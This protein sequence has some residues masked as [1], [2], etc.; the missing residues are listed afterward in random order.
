MY[1]YVSATVLGRSPGAQWVE[2]DLQQMPL[3]VIFNS[4]FGVYLTLTIPAQTDPLYV[5]LELLRPELS[6][7]PDTLAVWLNAIGNRTLP[8]VEEIPSS[9]VAYATFSDAFKAAYKVDT[10]R[11][12]DNVPIYFPPT[13]T[14]TALMTRPR[15]DTDLR[16]IDQYCLV[17][18]NGYFHRTASDQGSTYIYDGLTTMR[19]TRDNHVGILSFKDVGALTKIRLTPEQIYKQAA[20]SDLKTRTYFHI[21]QDITGKAVF[22]VL[23]GYLVFPEA[24]IF[25]PT[26]PKTFALNFG[27]LPLVERYLESRHHLDLSSLN[28][29]VNPQMP[30]LVN[31]SELFSDEVLTA[32]L[33]LSQSFLVIVDAPSLFTQRLYL[34][35]GAAPTMF[36]AFEEPRYPLILNNGQVAE[37]WSVKEDGQWSITVRDSFLR[38]RP[39]MTTTGE[40]VVNI[41]EQTLPARQYYR[42]R[43]YFLEIGTYN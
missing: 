21:P 14:T 37:Y 31:I 34:R 27:M 18:I 10:P 36:V 35:R 17:S 6:A 32:Y 42:S 40:D 26:G 2:K 22:L 28:L 24:G 3:Y 39:Y 15:Y 9:Q 11:P 5:N 43:G 33:T 20:G 41:T 29:T 25:W 4:Y 23:G 8:T 16:L 13:D 12:G 30:D 1:T 19:K 7:V 38:Y